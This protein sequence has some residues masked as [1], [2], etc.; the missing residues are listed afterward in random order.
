MRKTLSKIIIAA[1]SAVCIFSLCACN[2]DTPTNNQTTSTS[3]PTSV[4]KGVAVHR[5]KDGTQSSAQNLKALNCGW[6]Y[7]WGS[8]AS[9][10]SDGNNAIDSYVGDSC[11]F[12]PM[13][14]DEESMNSS[15]LESIKTNYTNGN[16]KYLLTF[17][18]PDISSQA[19]MT[20]DEALS[21]W[22]E[23]EEIGIPLSSPAVSQVDEE[24]Y[25]QWL[26][27]FMKQATIQGKRVDFIAVHLYQNFYSNG[28]VDTLETT[29]TAL[30]EKYKLPIWLTEFGASDRVAEDTGTL[31]EDCTQKNTTK[32]LTEATDVLEQLGCVARYAWFVDNF[33]RGGNGKP[34]HMPY[35]SLYND[36][37]TISDTGTAYKEITSNYP[38]TINTVKL[39]EAT[40]NK[41]Y[42]LQIS[43]CG[44]TGN[45]TF[46]AKSMPEGLTLSNEGIISGK[47][48]TK[49][50]YNIKITITDSGT[51]KRK[52]TLTRIYSLKIK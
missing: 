14:W 31:N 11:E 46:S 41:K 38:L 26:D 43:V 35:S 51:A 3:N 39:T 8:Y 33:D 50:S 6:Y 48:T 27:E 24:G 5:Y 37:D 12:V 29:L 44:G 18:E 9:Y 21:Y 1:L 49:G 4:K 36:D 47:P 22:D 52:Q 34:F 23:L 30:Y 25:N 28:V 17:N 2:D 19:N 7:N 16:Y 13:I 40:V 20:V 42:N 15:I 10:T 32:Y 45:Y